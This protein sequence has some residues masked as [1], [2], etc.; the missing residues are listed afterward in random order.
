MR[1]IAFLLLAF[2]FLLAA[3]VWAQTTITLLTGEQLVVD[4]EVR[5]KNGAFI[6]SDGRSFP[7]AQVKEVLFQTQS[8]AGKTEWT[9]DPERYARLFAK[10][11]ELA[12]KYPGRHGVVLEDLGAYR[13]NDDGTNSFTY[14]F[15]AL[16]LKEKAKSWARMG[17]GA[18]P[19]RH[20][21]DGPHGLVVHPDGGYVVAGDADRTRTNP[22]QGTQFFS[23]FF[24]RNLTVPDVRLGD[25]VEFW[26]T[27]T[28]TQ[29]TNPDFFFPEYMFQD[30][31]PV[32]RSEV[33]VRVPRGKNLHYQTL[34][35]PVGAAA[36]QV[37]VD[38]TGGAIYR[39]AL[40]DVPPLE[41]E[42]S[43][44]V[45]WEVVP[46]MRAT[47]FADWNE[48]FDHLSMFYRSRIVVTE[49]VR[50][51]TLA[52]VGDAQNVHEKIARIYHFVQRKI[53]Y[54]SIKTDFG[55]GMTGHAAEVTLSNGY[56][57]CT[58]KS[59]L[60]AAMLRVIG[61]E[62]HPIFLQTWGGRRD[63]Y[64]LPNLG[65]NHSISRLLVNGKEMFLDATASTY[66]YPHFR[67]DDQG[68][69]YVDPLGR[70]VGRITRMPARENLSRQEWDIVLDEQGGARIQ[71]LDKATGV[72]EAMI[73]SF[74]EGLDE[75]E[76]QKHLQS[77]V[78][79]YGPGARLESFADHHVADLELPL[80]SEMVFTMPLLAKRSGRFRIV[81]LLELPSHFGNVNTETRRFDLLTTPFLATVEK[82]Y[83][84]KLPPGW[85]VVELPPAR[86]IDSP[87]VY[88]RG[89]YTRTGDGFE[90]E[91]QL[92]FRAAEVPAGQY[93]LY[94]QNLVD[95]EAFLTQRAFV[96]EVSR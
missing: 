87:L 80:W 31:S 41:T 47:V 74:L 56:G 33:S 85:R 6:L 18:Q 70:T 30:T 38:E 49:P 39:W 11:R 59:I 78:A 82:I 58:D 16:I 84:V 17:V 95:I 4:G 19:G 20:E 63:Q 40:T 9:Y 83:R 66:R 94:R 37:S 96:E 46:S 77:Q 50:Q 64:D 29:P 54:I 35:M 67:Y 79:V 55:S 51:T 43:M 76:R 2:L 32:A 14:H 62:S 45:Q 81:D 71:K 10:G 72:G 65:G 48:I 75:R 88:F 42:P 69:P 22:Y 60:M 36:P 93:P 90:L 34:R 68:M 3:P 73:R 52:V 12:A 53:R 7:R 5:F 25:I 89:N 15:T 24:V 61:V 28:E 21:I 44:P 57:D 27:S 23:Q 8:E 1:R 26:Y 86:E 91:F 92:V 13:L